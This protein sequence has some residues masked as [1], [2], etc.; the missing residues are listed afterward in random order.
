MLG[1]SVQVLN[2]P[3]VSA[4]ISGGEPLPFDGPDETPD[5]ITNARRRHAG[6]CLASSNVSPLCP[7][8]VSTSAPLLP[9]SAGHPGREVAEAIR[10]GTP[11]SFMTPVRCGSRIR[12]P[13]RTWWKRCSQ[14]R[15]SVSRRGSGLGT[16]NEA[17]LIRCA[18]LCKRQDQPREALGVG[19]QVGQRHAELLCDGFGG[20]Q[21]RD[22]HTVLI[23]VDPGPALVGV[24]ADSPP[25]FPL[26]NT[27]PLPRKA[28]AAGKHRQS[29][30]D[31]HAVFPRGKAP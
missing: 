13:Y 2:L 28:Q 30:F 17:L 6:M 19:E 15:T 12:R 1:T 21:M 11:S 14:S 27:Q 20:F 4:C 5:G 31:R 3:S 7:D 16:A 9:A 23:L 24:H 22:V 18:H 25:E 29:D 8:T 26:G 10:A